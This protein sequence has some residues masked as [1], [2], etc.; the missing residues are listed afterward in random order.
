METGFNRDLSGVRIHTDDPA[1]HAAGSLSARAYVAG[2]HVVFAKDSY[3][4]DTDA[5]RWLLAHEL[6][7][8]NQQAHGASNGLIQRSPGPPADPAATVD[9]P[10]F[11]VTLPSA[12]QVVTSPTG[13]V[14]SY[15]DNR[16]IALSVTPEAT[17]LMTGPMAGRPPYAYE[18]LPPQGPDLLWGTGG[19]GGGPTRPYPI[20]RVVV[21]PGVGIRL[22]G[23][24]EN[25]I[26]SRENPIVEVFRVQDP[27]QIPPPDTHIDPLRYAGVVDLGASGT[28]AQGPIQGL[29]AGL[30]LQ[31]VPDL[32]TRRR[33]DGVD[34]IHSK[35][36][37]FS[38]TAPNLSATARFAYQVI[39]P[40]PSGFL[41]SVGPQ[42]WIVKVVKTQSVEVVIKGV[43][44]GQL[45]MD[46]LPEVYEVATIAEVPTQGTPIAQVGRLL[47]SIPA[48]S[49]MTTEQTLAIAVFETAI[50]FIPIVG[51]L[52]NLAEAT[53]GVATGRDFWGRRMTALDITL[54][55]LA[56]L[57][58]Y[59]GK[60]AGLVKGVT[61]A[62]RGAEEVSQLARAAA[63][64]TDAERA[65]IGRWEG[66]IRAGQEI[67]AA[68]REALI[69][70]LKKMDAATGGAERAAAEALQATEREV[71]VALAPVHGLPTI[72]PY[73]TTARLARGNLG[74]RLAAEALAADG[75]DILIYKPS[76]M[77]TNQGGIDIV[78]LHNGV[79]YLI[80]NKA[81]TRSGNVSSV[82]ALTTNFTQNLN[83]TRLDLVDMLAKAASEQERA[84]A[85]QAL[86]ALDTGNYVRAVTN[87]NVARDTKILSGVTSNLHGQGIRFID[88]FP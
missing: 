63:V 28:G 80:D 27:A 78:S 2:S 25:W 59:A 24:P 17:A 60:A 48:E 62:A 67:P 64:L 47:T 66:L 87:A 7:H 85:Q 37:V 73:S 77:G 16:R 65:Q 18:Y 50:S 9:N 71:N 75:H 79:L 41:L 72:G 61:S 44:R 26:A 31:L 83:T 40:D 21:G 33:A 19:A 35:G 34:F 56:A 4:P 22:S 53:Y 86:G 32:I 6:A 15:Q 23:F 11:L 42:P 8:V 36:T 57:L 54:L 3:Q 14:L 68:E 38:V 20:I 76:I 49:R 88:V 82:S 13:A 39:A 51:N 46:L 84:I 69:A 55:G 58:P 52:Y 74:E 10:I 1:A 43:V 45:L 70:L 81:L 12:F 29:P 5:G 30:G